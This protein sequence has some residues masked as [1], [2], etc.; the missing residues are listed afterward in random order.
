MHSNSNTMSDDRGRDPGLGR[1]STRLQLNIPAQTGFLALVSEGLRAVFEQAA[2]RAPDQD[3]L[4]Y[5]VQLAVQEACT[6]IVNHAYAEAA[7]GAG[8]IALDIACGPDR[9]VVELEDT[10]APFN[11]PPREAVQ[12][13]V[14]PQEHGYGL[15]LI[16]SL[17]DEVSYQSVAG[18]NRLVLVKRLPGPEAT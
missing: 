15:F 4:L 6:N 7:C 9:I 16:Y 12:L 10:G 3:A 18:V 2:G 11:L 17:V 5:G 13:P 14:E 8:R 1:G